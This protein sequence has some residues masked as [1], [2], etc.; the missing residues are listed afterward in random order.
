MENK[1]LVMEC[2]KRAVLL[3]AMLLLLCCGCAPDA[4]SDDNAAPLPDGVFLLPEINFGMSIKEVCAAYPEIVELSS[5][6]GINTEQSGIRI[7]VLSLENAEIY[8]ERANIQLQFRQQEE[9]VSEEEQ[10]VG[11]TYLHDNGLYTVTADFTGDIDEEVML[12]RLKAYFIVNRDN[13]ST[14]FNDNATTY[15]KHSYT[16]FSKRHVG[17]MSELDDAVL[18][19]YMLNWPVTRESDGLQTTVDCSRYLDFAIEGS[20]DN[21]YLVRGSYSPEDARLYLVGFFEGCLY[22]A[23]TS[24]MKN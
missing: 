5:M 11:E 2:V 8:G 18:R 1:T 10:A 4:T 15:G 14:F 23:N 7:T 22:A 6:Y 16:L 21:K 9:F 20:R 17:N 13:T 19:A 12:S 3:T 24:E